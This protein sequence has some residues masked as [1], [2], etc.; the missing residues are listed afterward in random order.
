MIHAVSCLAL[1]FI[2]QFRLHY[3]DY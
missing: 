1:Q 3:V 2:L